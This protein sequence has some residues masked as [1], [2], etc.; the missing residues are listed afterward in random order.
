MRSFDMSPQAAA[1][2]ALERELAE[3]EAAIALVDSGKT[4]SVTIAGVRHGEAI[5]ESRRAEA[6]LRGIAVEADWGPGEDDC[7]IVVRRIDG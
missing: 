3:L 5:V 2:R 1:E 4:R 7:D 6:A